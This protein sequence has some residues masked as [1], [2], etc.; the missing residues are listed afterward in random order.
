MLPAQRTI[1]LACHPGGADTDLA[2]H[3]PSMIYHFV[4]PMAQMV[5]NSPEEGALPTLR[6]ATD[7]AQPKPG[8]CRTS[9]AIV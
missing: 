3:M 9:V 2:R 5:I 1:S 4:R 7:L 8:G 6:A